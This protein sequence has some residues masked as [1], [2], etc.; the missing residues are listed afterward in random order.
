MVYTRRLGSGPNSLFILTADGKWTHLGMRDCLSLREEGLEPMWERGSDPDS[1][2]IF[3][4]DK[5]AHSLWPRKGGK[6]RPAAQKSGPHVPSVTWAD[7]KF[8]LLAA[9]QS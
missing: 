9:P 8:T 5:T 1:V 4:F 6:T 3:G 2:A 7:T